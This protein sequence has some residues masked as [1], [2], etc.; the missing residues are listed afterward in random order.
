[1]REW[2]LCLIEV[3]GNFYINMGIRNGRI[4]VQPIFTLT[5]RSEDAEI[6][7]MLKEEIGAGESRIG[8]KAVFVV[9]GIKNL[10]KFLSVIDE[11]KFLT[12]RKKD[13]ILW[14]EA[15]QLVKEFKHLTKEGILRICEIRDMMNLKK[16]R[17]NYKSKEFFERIINKLNM[18]F[19]NEEKRSKISSSLRRTY[20]M[21]ISI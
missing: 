11:K 7:K 6:L 2:F 3:K 1:M 21:G 12:S 16:K 14:K 15:I 17:K 9:R 10:E 5:L 19:E 8:K 4:F 18:G 13:F 20:S